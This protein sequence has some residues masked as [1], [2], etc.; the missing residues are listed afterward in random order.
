MSAR[1]QKATEET[2]A[3]AA[4]VADET[5]TVEQ[6]PDETAPVVEEQPMV[7]QPTEAAVPSADAQQIPM[8]VTLPVGQVLNLR[9]GPSREFRVLEQIPAQTEV[10][11]VPMPYGIQV[12]GWHLI[13]LED[14]VGW[15]AADYLRPVEG[16]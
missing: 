15:A 9:E 6:A 2:A 3:Q 5:P 1:K 7:E 12:P 16:D 14:R 8:V 11:A 13:R 10:Q 4:P